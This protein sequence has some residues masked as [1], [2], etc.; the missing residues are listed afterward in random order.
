MK[1]KVSPS[2][3][4]LLVAQQVAKIMAVYAEHGASYLSQNGG[5]GGNI[6]ISMEFNIE[7]SGGEPVSIP[8]CSLHL[9]NSFK[10]ETVPEEW[11]S[12]TF[13]TSSEIFRPDLNDDASSIKR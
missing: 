7:L 4:T 13:P 9:D 6:Q 8:E 3:I 11:Q 1:A 10:D 12:V 2:D 5:N